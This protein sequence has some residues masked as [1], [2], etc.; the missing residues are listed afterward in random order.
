MLDCMD[1][2][3]FISVLNLKILY[4]L[5]F[6]RQ[7]NQEI[8]YTLKLNRLNWKDSWNVFKQNGAFKSNPN[9]KKLEVQSSGPSKTVISRNNGET[10][11]NL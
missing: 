9:H 6:R 7:I 8:Q 10:E 2:V 5:L 4:F 3:K 11:K 1:T